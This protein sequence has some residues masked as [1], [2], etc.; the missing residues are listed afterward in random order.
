MFTSSSIYC[1]LFFSR[2][3]ISLTSLIFF[4]YQTNR[5]YHYR[6]PT[7]LVRTPM[8]LFSTACNSV[9]SS[10]TDHLHT[11]AVP[12]SPIKSVRF[13]R[14]DN[15]YTLIRLLE[16]FIS[17]RISTFINNKF[18]IYENSALIHADTSIYPLH[19]PS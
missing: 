14:D 19:H 6:R 1:S 7:S 12:N 16:K 17:G 8:L 15:V 5:C 18:Y 2:K 4:T 10:F 11:F 3:A 13:F 9:N